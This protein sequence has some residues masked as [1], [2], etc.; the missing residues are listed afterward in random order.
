MQFNPM[1]IDSLMLQKLARTTKTS[2]RSI[3]D[4]E[5]TRTSKKINI[6]SKVL[7]KHFPTHGINLNHINSTNFQ[8]TKHFIVVT[9]VSL[10][11]IGPFKINTSR[12]L[13]NNHKSFNRYNTLMISIFF[14]LKNTLL[15][16]SSQYATFKI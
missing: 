14:L 11:K 8:L 16:Y 5:D 15:T 12:T 1:P 3:N 2:A 10:N 13:E 6:S 9:F 7:K 4:T